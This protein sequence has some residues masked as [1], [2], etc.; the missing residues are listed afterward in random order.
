MSK[1][2]TQPLRVPLPEPRDDSERPVSI[3]RAR[4]R[5]ASPRSGAIALKGRRPGFFF[6]LGLAFG[7]GA[8]LPLARVLW[9]EPA[10][11]QVPVETQIRSLIEASQ[12]AL[13]LGRPE[14]AL[15]LLVTA[16]SL[17][18]KNEVVQNN[19]CVTFNMLHRHDDAIEACKIALV[20]NP[21][22]ALA[23]NNLRWAQAELAKAENRAPS[24][25]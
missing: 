25:R 21:D 5:G 4:Q 17:G 13:S 15:P 20:L 11:P 16:D 22:F 19:L 6:V 18:L 1:N 14:Q 10:K 9:R 23:R 8:A 7:V 12:E 24:A 3:L 2:S